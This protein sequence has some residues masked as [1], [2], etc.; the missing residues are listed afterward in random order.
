M[1]NK[2]ISLVIVIGVFSVG[3]LWIKGASQTD[4]RHVEIV[5][6]SSSVPAPQVGQKKVVL[7]N[8]R[9]A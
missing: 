2:W 3:F 5:S 1:H 4:G 9:M 8:L 6:S 7:K